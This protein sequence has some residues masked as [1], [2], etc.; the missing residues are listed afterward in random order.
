[1]SF[2]TTKPTLVCRISFMVVKKKPLI[3]AQVNISRLKQAVMKLNST[4]GL[5]NKT[6][7]CPSKCFCL[8]P[9]LGFFTFMMIWKKNVFSNKLS[10]S[11]RKKNNQHSRD[12]TFLD[13]GS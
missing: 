6:T 4:L 11:E 12:Q 13:R 5:T 9:Q 2:R 3:P 1:M 10:C 8:N 7:V